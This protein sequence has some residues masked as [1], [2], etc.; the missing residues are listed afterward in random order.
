MI[1]SNL[2]LLANKFGLEVKRYNPS[3]S[4]ASQLAAMLNY[5]KIDLVLDIGANVGQFGNDLRKQIK[6]KGK[7]VSFEPMLKEHEVLQK[8][9]KN[10]DNWFVAERSAIGSYNGFVDIN[11]SKNS[12]S[13]SLLSMLDTHSNAAPDSSYISKESV[14][15]IKLDDAANKYLDNALNIFLKIDTQGYEMQ[16]LEGATKTLD[17]CTGVQL[18]LSLVNLYSEQSNIYELI[19]KMRGLGFNLWGIS[20]VFANPDS[21][22]M[23]QVDGTFFR[24]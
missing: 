5:H 21:G 24:N 10:D 20:P 23:L 1:I 9:S 8:A 4:Q 18:E 19:E 11:V 2:K 3:N 13:S 15:L 17:K 6:Y 14:P 12:V 16:V 7:I 22:Q